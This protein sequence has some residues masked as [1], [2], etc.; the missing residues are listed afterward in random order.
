MLQAMDNMADDISGR[1]REF[2]NVTT[3]DMKEVEVL[4]LDLKD[5]LYFEYIKTERKIRIKCFYEQ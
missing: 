1:K 3:S 4:K 2:Y 5:I